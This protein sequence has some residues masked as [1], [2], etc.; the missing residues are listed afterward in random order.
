MAH[1]GKYYPKIPMHNQEYIVK[2]CASSNC[3]EMDMPSRMGGCPNCRS[4]LY[5]SPQCQHTDHFNHNQYC[6]FYKKWAKTEYEIINE[7]DKLFQF[8]NVLKVI[9]QSTL[10]LKQ[11]FLENM[12]LHNKGIWKRMCGCFNKI[13]YGELNAFESNE[14]NECKD[15]LSM[16]MPIFNIKTIIQANDIITNWKEYYEFKQLSLKSAIAHWM[17]WPMTIYYSLTKYLKMRPNPVK[18]RN[19]IIHLVGVEVE[20]D[21][22][23]LFQELLCLLPGNTF[24]FYLFGDNKQVSDKYVDGHQVVYTLN[25]KEFMEFNIYKKIYS[26]NSI[27]QKSHQLPDI[28]FAFNAGLS[29]AEYVWKSAIYHIIKNQIPA[30]FT[31]YYKHSIWC[32]EK[33]YGAFT[34][35]YIT[36]PFRSPLV[37]FMMETRFSS[38]T[39]GFICTLN[40]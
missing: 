21:L 18:P 24:I 16:R 30:V 3:T 34:K 25:K 8:E 5:C 40:I 14:N 38:I 10:S 4:V 26:P 32:N 1:A 12:N 23:Y 31:E 6:D 9:N 7:M 2:Q 27:E 36:N 33:T 19:I 35:K 17:S 39:N 13:R 28:V 11:N 29:S 20:L 22:L 15:Q 37:D